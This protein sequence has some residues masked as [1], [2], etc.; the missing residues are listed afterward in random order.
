MSEF[1]DQFE[2]LLKMAFTSGIEAQPLSFRSFQQKNLSRKEVKRFYAGCHRGYDKAQNKIFKMLADLQ[3]DTSLAEEERLY[4]ESL[5]RKTMDGIAATFLR[6]RIHLMRRLVIHNDAPH[7]NLKVVQETLLAANKLNEESRMTFAIVAD[8]TTFIQ[9]ADILRIDF[10]DGTPN[11]SLI[12]LKTGKVNKMLLDKLEEYEPKPG[13]LARLRLDQSIDQRH[14]KQAERMLR[15]QIR[16]AQVEQIVRTDVGA[17]LQL[18]M[19]VIWSREETKLPSYAKFLDRLCSTAVDEGV[20]AGTVAR[21]LH[22]GIGYAE[23]EAAAKKN[24]WRG[25]NCAIHESCA[26]QPDGMAKII[27]ETA[28]FVPSNQMFTFTENYRSNLAATAVRP[29]V[30]WELKKEHIHALARKKLVILMSFD[31]VGFIW[32]CRHVIGMETKFG[33]R[34]EAAELA[35]EYGA[36]NMVTWDGRALSI[37]TRNGWSTLFGGILSRFANGLSNPIA[38]MNGVMNSHFPESSEN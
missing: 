8:L 2:G 18:N 34:R 6:D 11:I 31:I 22:F 4:R 29:F 32:L 10:R 28:K 16:R 5:L 12:E 1:F 17:D 9:I 14:V 38:F 13:E 26:S 23:D 15:Q 27:E 35:R 37:R 30:Q 19:K 3:N 24:A 25:V 33:T 36:N 7:I 21:C 20:A